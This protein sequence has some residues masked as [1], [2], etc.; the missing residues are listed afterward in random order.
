TRSYGDWSSD[1]CSSDLPQLAG[2]HLQEEPLARRRQ[3]RADLIVHADHLLRMAMLG[4]ADVAFLDRGWPAGIA[5]QRLVVDVQ[6]LHQL[7][8]E[9]RR[10]GKGCRVRWA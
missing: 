10:V 3:R 2:Q 9:E 1:V 4:P 7:R 6:L 8:S 5:H